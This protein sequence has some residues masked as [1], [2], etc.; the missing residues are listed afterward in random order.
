MS[1]ETAPLK[2]FAT[3]ARTALIREVTCPLASQQV[4]IDLD[5]GVKVNC[6]KLSAALKEMPGLEAVE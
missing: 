1:L 3:W 6:P 5:D 2:S 4:T